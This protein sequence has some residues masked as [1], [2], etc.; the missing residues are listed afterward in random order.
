MAIKVGINGFGRIGRNIMRA[1]RGN[2]DIDIV[3][4][5]DIT[6]T[7]TLAH[8]LKYDSI[9]GN[10]DVPVEAGGD[11]IRVG[12]DKF[13]VL[14]QKDPAALPWQQ[15]G[16]EIVFESTGLFTKREDAAKHVAGG[17]K[18]VIITAPATGPDATFVMGVNHDQYDPGKP[19]RRLERV[20]HDE[21]PGAGRQG[22]ERVV[23]HREGVDD[24][25]PLLHQRPAAPRS[26]AQ[27]Y[28]PR[29]RRVAVD[30][31][32]DD[33]GGEGGRRGP[34]GAQGPSRRVLDA[35][36]DAEHFGRRPRGRCSARRRRR[37]K[38]TRRS[39]P[40]RPVRCPGILAVEDAPLVSI[41]FRGNPNSSIVDSAYTQAH[42][43]RFRQGPVVVRQRVGLFDAL[44]RSDA[45]HGSARPLSGRPSRE[46]R[47]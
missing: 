16:A 40:P 27:G 11:W 47:R 18:R 32:D 41:D 31:P 6:D 12:A 42:G 14:A 8:L 15:L 13:Q 7:A 28:P 37:T 43:R 3:A 10:L 22:A 38:S 25:D 39:A 30:D 4:V 33:R 44:R 17:A 2:A 45:A 1:A 29:P 26:A 20:V 19:R 23:R 35:G 34:A 9:L 21:L 24:D 36:A 5:N 46:S